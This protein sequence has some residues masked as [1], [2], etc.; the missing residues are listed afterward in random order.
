MP[1][2]CRTPHI[3]SL[4][5]QVHLVSFVLRTYA[6]L[7]VSRHGA[8]FARS[9]ESEL[10]DSASLD[11]QALCLDQMRIENR[12]MKLKRKKLKFVLLEQ[13]MFKPSVY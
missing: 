10:S 9:L 1:C 11:Y 6:P 7:T 4:V 12:I 5:A 2:I 8:I 3:C 13:R